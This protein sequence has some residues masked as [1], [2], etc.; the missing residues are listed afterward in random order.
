[1]IKKWN[2]LI[3]LSSPSDFSASFSIFSSQFGADFQKYMDS[4]W[5]PVAEKYSNAWT[6]SITHFDNRTT[7]RIES[8]HAF[9]KSHLLGPNHSFTSVVKMITNALEAQAHKISAH[10]HQ[11]K[12]NS[13]LNLAKIFENCHGRITHYALRK[14]QNNLT[15][16]SSLKKTATCNGF[17]QK[18]TGIPC[19]H[20]S[21]ELVDLGQLVEPEEFHPQWH[22]KVSFFPFFISPFLFIFRLFEGERRELLLEKK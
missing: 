5:L 21:A 3:R 1:M 2:D 13:L 18:R 9:I 17:H 4:Q 8:G 20:R 11:Q 14:A 12:I 19:K 15:T 7:S 6:K 16:I 22:I 10:F